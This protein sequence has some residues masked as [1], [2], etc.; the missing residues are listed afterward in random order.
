MRTICLTI[1]TVICLNTLA[2]EDT[3]Y[4][5]GANNK[6]TDPGNAMLKRTIVKSSQKKYKIFTYTLQNERWE[7]FSYTVL[8]VRNENEYLVREY[9]DGRMEKMYKRFYSET[10]QGLYDF[11]ETWNDKLIRTGTSGTRIPLTLEGKEIRYYESGQ[12]KSES[13]YRNNQLA[14]NSNWL[15]SGEKYIDNVFYSVDEYPE[16]KAGTRMLHKYLSEHIGQSGFNTNNLDGT[17]RIGF[18]ITGTGEL[19]GVYA[20]EGIMPEFDEIVEDAVRSI[21][22]EWKPAVLDK[23]E[24]NCF[25][26]I[27]INFRR[28][29]AMGFENLELTFSN[30]IWMMYW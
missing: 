23:N 20:T 12:K 27:P 8:K 15:K 26:T 13:V 28:E 29:A 3:T 25:L 2:G 22:G 19:E 21:P 18:V 7:I 1:L 17:V 30:N 5:Y 11:S 9:R 10:P 16:Y 14:S 24:V 4:Y 6:P